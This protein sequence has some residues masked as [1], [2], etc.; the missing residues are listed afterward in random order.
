M[1][2]GGLILDGNNHDIIV[3]LFSVSIA[4]EKVR[5]Q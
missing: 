5:T 2:S 4:F 1:G 3:L